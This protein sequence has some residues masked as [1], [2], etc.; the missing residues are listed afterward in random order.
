MELLWFLKMEEIRYIIDIQI[1][2]KEI[3]SSK[4]KNKTLELK[5]K[6]IQLSFYTILAIGCTIGIQVF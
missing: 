2:I 5:K 3:V 1:F 4:N 6:N